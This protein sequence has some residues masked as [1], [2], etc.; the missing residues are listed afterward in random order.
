M[1][2]TFLHVSVPHGGGALVRSVVTDHAGELAADGFLVPRRPAL[3]RRLVR[4][5]SPRLLS[6]LKASELDAVVLL[7][8]RGLGEDAAVKR[9]VDGI[10]GVGR[11]DVHAVI[12]ARPAA[13]QVPQLW[14]QRVLDG[15]EAT[16]REFF[17]AQVAEADGDAMPVALD[18]AVV[19][20][21]WARALPADHVHVVVSRFDDAERLWG[22]FAGVIGVPDPAAYRPS[23]VVLPVALGPDGAEVCRRVNAQHDAR[24]SDQGR[25][26]WIRALFDSDVLR[27]MPPRARL[28]VPSWAADQVQRWGATSAEALTAAGVDVVGG[29]D[30]LVRPAP[31]A[32]SRPAD[33]P[34]EAVVEQLITWSIGR[35]QELWVSLAPQQTPPDVGVDD[36]L[37]GLI[38]MI[39]HCRAAEA[40]TAARPRRAERAPRR[41]GLRRR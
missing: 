13:D 36:G 40:K 8:R 7:E 24:L 39:E 5:A 12:T 2:S 19:A 29:L 17:D 27:G 9:F 37:A 28:A 10:R 18:P 25:G 16:F 34:D 1:T 30:D 20:A 21:R 6:A 11:A 38:E 35:L 15:S 3:K 22:R 14:R 23:D 4:A 33:E 31:L 32:G 26:P 41:W